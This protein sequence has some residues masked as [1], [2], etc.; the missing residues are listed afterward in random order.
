MPLAATSCNY[1]CAAI[2]P[3]AALRKERYAP[4][5]PSLWSRC[6]TRSLWHNLKSPR[7]PSIPIRFD[8]HAANRE[9]K[10]PKP[11][12]R[13]AA[14]S[15]RTKASSAHH[16]QSP[17]PICR[18]GETGADISFGEVR[19]L[20]QNFF[21]SHPGSEVIEHIEHRDAHPADARFSTPLARLDGDGLS[22]IHVATKSLRPIKRKRR[23]SLT[24]PTRKTW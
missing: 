8:P 12:L 5:N 14:N 4:R 16:G 22:V 24:D 13:P 9:K 11:R 19:K 21:V 7:R 6:R 23:Q 15:R 10:P 1:P 18:I 2:S 20:R 3:W 17:L